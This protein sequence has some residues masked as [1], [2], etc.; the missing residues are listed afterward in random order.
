M[1]RVSSA[2]FP[3][4]ICQVVQQ[5]GEQVRHRC[6]FSWWCDGRSDDP[7]DH[8]AWRE[9]REIAWDVLR[10]AT[11]DPTLGALWYHADYVSPEWS[12]DLARGRQIGRHIFYLRTD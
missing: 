5:G 11:R 1:N 10:G 9:S 6:Q 2:G 8:L 7:L 3:S 12:A 4:T